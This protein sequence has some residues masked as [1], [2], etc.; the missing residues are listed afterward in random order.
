MRQARKILANL[1]VVCV[2]LVSVAIKCHHH[3]A[4][5]HVCMCLIEHVSHEDCEC[6]DPEDHTHNSAGASIC[7][8]GWAYC[9][10]VQYDN[11]SLIDQLALV[12]IDVL[13]PL[14]DLIDIPHAIKYYEAPDQSPHTTAYNAI[15]VR[16]GPPSDI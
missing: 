16:R 6:G 13:L 1:L 11:D 14:P 9:V 2:A 4:C 8:D 5:N 3:D 7:C 15:H 12:Q 10:P